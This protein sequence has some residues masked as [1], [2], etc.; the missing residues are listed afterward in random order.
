MSAAVQQAELNANAYNR[1]AQIV[2]PSGKIDQGALQK[3][4]TQNSN[5]LS[6]EFG[7]GSIT[8]NSEGII[9]EGFGTD[10]KNKL[11]ITGKGIFITKD[12]GETWT[13]VMR[14]TGTNASTLTDGTL[15]VST[16]NIVD[17]GAPSFQWNGEGL[18]AYGFEDLQ[19][20]PTEYTQGGELWVQADPEEIP[21]SSSGTWS[22]VN[23]EGGENNG[24]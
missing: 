16:I 11:K 1:A 2:Q 18:T 21:V 6:M 24:D 10:R 20:D 9:I 12:N 3:T 22:V 7:T 23:N 17:A 15:D 4:F 14:G 8:Q 19:F 13:P 5:D